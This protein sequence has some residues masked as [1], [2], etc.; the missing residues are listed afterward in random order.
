MEDRIMK[1]KSKIL[2]AVLAVFFMIAGNAMAIQTVDYTATG[3]VFDFTVSNDLTGYGIYRVGIAPTDIVNSVSLDSWTLPSDVT[4]R[5]A[6]GHY[7]FNVSPYVYGVTDLGTIE[8]TYATLPNEF[9]YAIL[10]EGTS[11]YTGTDAIYLGHSK[12][13]GLY[14]Y[15]FVGKAT[16]VPEPATLILLG[17]GLLGVIGVRKKMHK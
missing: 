10:I 11:A 14:L 13:N 17:L 2:M 5:G 4:Y 3:N 1:I 9:D 8:I 12:K 15:E 6:N 7:W 16:S